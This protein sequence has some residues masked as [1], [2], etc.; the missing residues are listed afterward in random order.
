MK[1]IVILGLLSILVIGC[2]TT[3][4]VVTDNTFKQMC[5]DDGNK[6]MTMEP[7]VDGVPTGQA[8]CTGC[9][10]GGTHF[11]N[12]EEYM[13]ALKSGKDMGSM[14]SMENMG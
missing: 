3:G 14:D 13:K 7:T 9:M 1:A 10:I 5:K 11:C 2:S 12:Q 6:F 8:K 4:N